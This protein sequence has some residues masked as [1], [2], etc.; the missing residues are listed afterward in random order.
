MA[1]GKVFFAESMFSESSNGSKIALIALMG[2]LAFNKFVLLDVQFMTDHLKSMGAR[3]IS[4]AL[5]LKILKRSTS[6]QAE[7]KTNGNHNI[8]IKIIN[9]AEKTY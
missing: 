9:E 5:F 8:N 2:I 4:R 1:I 3:E 6:Y 7:F